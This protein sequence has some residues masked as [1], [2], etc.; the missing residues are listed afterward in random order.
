MSVNLYDSLKSSYG[1]KKSQENLK[2]AG[3][4][5]DSMLSNHNQQVWYNPNTKKLL[6]NVAGTHN[7]S[8]VGTDVWLAFGGL[9]NTNRYKEASKIL[10]EAKRKYGNDI[11]TTITGHSL[12][13]TIGQYIA[14]KNDNFY[15]LDG[16]YTIGQPTRSNNG[17]QHHFR[18]SGDV[19]SLLGANAKHMKTLNNYNKAQGFAPL[20]ALKAHDIDS[21]KNSG[22]FID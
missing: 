22:I 15:G 5:Y 8:D 19:V 3:Y 14:N 11:N 6:Y 12:G 9:K 1:N 10:D 13:S 4:K 17:K 16:G 2:R 7:L 20:D 21:I 18:T